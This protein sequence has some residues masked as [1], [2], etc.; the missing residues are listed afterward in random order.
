MNPMDESN[1]MEMVE[2][3]LKYEINHAAY[4]EFLASAPLPWPPLAKQLFQALMYSIG[5][6]LYKGPYE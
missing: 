4:W 1:W 3:H 6:R 5:V 2:E